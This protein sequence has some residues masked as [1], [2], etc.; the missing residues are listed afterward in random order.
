MDIKDESQLAQFKLKRLIRQLE[1]VE[2]SGTSMITCIIPPG[3]KISDLQKNLTEESG[4]AERIKDRAN[5]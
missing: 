1:S 4:K 5:R 2:G 3:K